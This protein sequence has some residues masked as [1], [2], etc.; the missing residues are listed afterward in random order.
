M[1]KRQ[2]AFLADGIIQ[3]LGLDAY[4]TA[5][6]AGPRAFFEAYE[7]AVQQRGRQLIPIAKVIRD[8]LAGSKRPK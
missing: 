8:R 2:G 1:Y 5:L 4:R 6:S 3:T 7:R